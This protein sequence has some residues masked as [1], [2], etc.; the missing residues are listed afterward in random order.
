MKNVDERAASDGTV[1]PA[2]EMFDP[3]SVAVRELLTWNGTLW[4][5]TA[6]ADPWM[7]VTAYDA[8]N[9]YLEATLLA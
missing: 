4:V 1:Y 3:T 8:E 2:V 6:S 5:H 7:I 9:E